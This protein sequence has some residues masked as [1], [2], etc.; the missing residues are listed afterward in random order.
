MDKLKRW[1]YITSALALLL[2][3]LWARYE[4]RLDPTKIPYEPIISAVL[5]LCGIWGYVYYQNKKEEAAPPTTTQQAKTI[6]NVEEITHATI[7]DVEKQQHFGKGAVNVE[8]QYITYAGDRKIP[9]FLTQT[10]SASTFFIGRDEDLAAIETDYQQHNRLLVLVNGEGGMGK[11]TLATHY[12]HRHEARYTHLAWVFAESGVGNAIM[13]LG[14]VLGVAFQ[15]QDNAVAQVAAAIHE[16]DAPCLFVLDN[17]NNASDLKQHFR[18]LKALTNCHILLTSRVDA[19]HDVTVHKVKPLKGDFPAQVFKKHYKKHLDSEESLLQALLHAVGYN[20]LVIELLAKN[21]AV[22]NKYKTTYSL[23]SL[24]ADLQ[25]KGLF[26]LQNRQVQVTYQTDALRTET[27]ENII[28]AMYDLSDLSDLERY[29]LSNFAVLPSENI[30]FATFIELLQPDD[31]I[32]LE[33][34]LSHLQQKGWIDYFEDSSSF[35]MSQV[36]QAITQ[37]K[38]KERLLNDVHALIKTLINTLDSDNL[39]DDFDKSVVFAGYAEAVAQAIDEADDHL[40]TLCQNLGDTHVVTGNLD[41]AMQTYGKMMSIQEALCQ[42]DPDNSDYKN[43]LAI[44]Y[45]KLGST[46]EALGNLDKALAFFE[47][48]NQL[49][50]VLYADYPN[51]VA[52]KNGLA[53]SY[54]KLGSTHEALG[55]LDKALAF[56]EEQTK[57]FEALYADYPNNVTFK[58]GLAIS[59]QYLGDT[60]TELGNLDKALAFFEKDIELSEALHADYPNNVVFKNGLAVSYQ[61]LGNTHTALGNLEKALAFFEKDIEL[62]EA[63]Y[64]DYPNN[65]AF[66]NGL[67]LS[68]SKLGWFLETK[69]NDKGGAKVHYEQSRMLLLALVK[70]SPLNVAFKKNLNWVEKQLGMLNK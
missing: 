43:G 53:I 14:Q 52:F 13:S 68:F 18:T 48:F 49:L 10:P 6:V 23:E 1:E 12:W 38:N 25:A 65:V 39:H 63:L 51:N 58:N 31:A 24:V 4:Y 42:K 54:S 5:T 2:Y 20:T 19:L 3:A 22:F 26:A 44:S 55:N 45:S 9:R 60:H 29:L 8:Q 33:A 27:P 46:H 50:E 21:L 36:I 64:A 37:R 17:A 70:D 11:T 59:Y 34:P 32:A 41:K 56:F 7:G 61:Y 69:K 16:L 35:K 40:A 66:K 47:Q 67:A 28:A 30:P 62:S 57:L 15:P